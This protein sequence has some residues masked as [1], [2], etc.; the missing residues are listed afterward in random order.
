MIQ[1]PVSPGTMCYCSYPFAR[2]ECTTG[3]IFCNPGLLHQSILSL[4]PHWSSRD[5][6]S[7]SSTKPHTSPESSLASSQTPTVHHNPL[8]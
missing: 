6:K 2:Y 7:S 4:P 1:E 8:P 5:S 3:F